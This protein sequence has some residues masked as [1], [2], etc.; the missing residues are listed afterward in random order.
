MELGKSA[1]GLPFP[2][3]PTVIFAN[4]RALCIGPVISGLRYPLLLAEEFRM[5]SELV[6]ARLNSPRR[7][8]PSR[9]PQVS[10]DDR[11]FGGN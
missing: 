5:S 7:G 2:R 8:S 9:G 3:V 10:A 6:T 1:G 11:A 4:W